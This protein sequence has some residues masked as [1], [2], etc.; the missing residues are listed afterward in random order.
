[1]KRIFDT[2]DVRAHALDRLKNSYCTCISAASTYY[3]HGILCEAL[4]HSLPVY[5]VPDRFE[6]FSFPIL[7][8]QV[9]CLHSVSMW[10]FK[11][12]TRLTCSQASIP[13]SGLY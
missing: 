7:V 2:S 8:L 10:V 12:Q 9:V 6:I 3:A 11:V 5:D 13:S 4:L 1:M